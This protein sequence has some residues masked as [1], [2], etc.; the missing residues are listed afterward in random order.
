MPRLHFKTAL[1]AAALAFT[2]QSQASTVTN[3]VTNGSFENLSGTGLGMNNW[4]VFTSI[5]GWTTASGA[6]IEL[7]NGNVA[8]V[9][10]FDGM[11]KVELDSHNAHSN[12]AM[13]QKLNLAA[14]KYMLS[15]AYM[16]RIAGNPGDTNRIDY[17]VLG[18]GLE[19]TISKSFGAWE[20]ITA[21]FHTN[22]NGVTLR[23]GA[24][25]RQ[26][27]LGGYIDSVAITAS[28]VPLP[29]GLP[30]LGAA[31]VG[32]GLVRRRTAS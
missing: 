22:G 19:G 10:A 14:G 25:G 28:P 5:T 13:I 23:F 8:G 9:N 27:T 24:G 7:H 30:L 1:L 6:G 3:F 4:N 11:V 18:A 21:M 26:D 17:S 32:L 12:S 16:G 31:L 15:F 29:A 2:T 20:I